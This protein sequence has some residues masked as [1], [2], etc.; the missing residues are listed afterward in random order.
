MIGGVPDCESFV[1]AIAGLQQLRIL[2]ADAVWFG[3]GY[4]EGD[5]PHPIM[6][7]QAA[8][9]L[10]FLDLWG[11]ED[12]PGKQSPDWAA[13]LKSLPG[14]QLGADLVPLKDKQMPTEQYRQWD[15]GGVMTFQPKS[16]SAELLWHGVAQ[17]Q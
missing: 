9:Q 2:R 6:R 1:G 8:T 11:L 10:I 12:H 5:G 14:V 4:A 16:V 3:S 17:H 13:L 7:L 15:V